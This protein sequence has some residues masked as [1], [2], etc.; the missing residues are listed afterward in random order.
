MLCER[1]ISVASRITW[2]MFRHLEL[3]SHVSGTTRSS[4]LIQFEISE[5]QL[6]QLPYYLIWT[7]LIVPR[8]KRLVTLVIS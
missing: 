7:L 1:P 5:Q 3:F 8:G 4:S 6:D 2:W